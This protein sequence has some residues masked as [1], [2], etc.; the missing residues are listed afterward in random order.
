MQRGKERGLRWDL[1]PLVTLFVL[2]P[3]IVRM[4]LVDNPLKEYPWF[5]WNEQRGDFFLYW[6]S[7]FLQI[8]AVWMLFVLADRRFIRSKVQLINVNRKMKKL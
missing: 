1:L 2:L 8:L 5:P 7:R 4:Q 3:L 6:K